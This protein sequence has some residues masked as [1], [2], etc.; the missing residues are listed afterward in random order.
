MALL[1]HAHAVE[2]VGE[3][4]SR[5]SIRPDSAPLPLSESARLS[6]VSLVLDTPGGHS[7]TLLPR[8]L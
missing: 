2:Q 1:L 6:G 3:V 8:Q 7:S 4:L 5:Q